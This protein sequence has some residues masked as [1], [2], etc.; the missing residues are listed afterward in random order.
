ETEEQE[1]GLSQAGIITQNPTAPEVGLAPSREPL[2][3]SLEQEEHWEED[4]HD[5]KDKGEE[6]ENEKTEKEGTSFRG[7]IPLTTDP[8]PTT[9]FTKTEFD[10]NQEDPRQVVCLNWSELAGRGY[11]ILNMTKNMNCVSTKNQES[12][13]FGTSNLIDSATFGLMKPSAS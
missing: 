6:M 5:L 8:S 7:I 3:P 11:V 1:T 4:E 10:L 2:Q 13:M 9:G 12:S